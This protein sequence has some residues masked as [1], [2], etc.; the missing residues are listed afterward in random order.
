M[1]NHSGP[2]S[3]AMHREVHGEALTGEKTGQPLSRE[4]SES[5]MPTL[6]VNA[7]GNTEHGAKSQAMSRSLA[8]VDPAHVRK[9]FARKLGDLIDARGG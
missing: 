7:E 5:G 2:E 1:A 3:C 9:P 8:V 4:I 6:C